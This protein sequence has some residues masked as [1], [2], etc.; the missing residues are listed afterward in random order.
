MLGLGFQHCHLFTY[1]L[2]ECSTV[3]VVEFLDFHGS[4]FVVVVFNADQ[5][6]LCCFNPHIDFG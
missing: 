5:M 6:I 4:V 3:K 1:L 2:F